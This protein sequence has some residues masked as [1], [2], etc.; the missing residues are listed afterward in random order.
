MKF[1]S[2]AICSIGVW[3]VINSF[4]ASIWDDIT[5]GIIVAVLAFIAMFKVGD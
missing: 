5:F 2:L 1:L 4:V 3:V